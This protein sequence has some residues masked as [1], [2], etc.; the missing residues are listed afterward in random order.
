MAPMASAVGD[1]VVVA[2]TGFMD[3][4]GV[5]KASMGVGRMAAAAIMTTNNSVSGVIMRAARGP[6]DEYLLECIIFF[7]ILGLLNQNDG[8]MTRSGRWIGANAGVK[9]M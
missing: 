9:S 5:I 4:L 7:W 6:L 8:Y 2:T 3:G 1:V